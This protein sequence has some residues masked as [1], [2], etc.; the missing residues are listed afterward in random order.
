MTVSISVLRGVDAKLATTLKGMG[1]GN[2]ASF[3]EATRTPAGR[4]DVAEKAGIS[5]DLVLELTNR[6]DLA[7]VKG[8]AQVYSDL[9]ENAGVDTVAE[10]ANRRP[11]HLAATLAEVNAGGK[12]TKRVPPEKLVAGWVAQAKAL[13]RGIE[14]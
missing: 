13:G 9:L 5:A 1:L 7:R 14:Y 4:R 2:S 6:A 3:L 12:F 10:L 8:I 11:D